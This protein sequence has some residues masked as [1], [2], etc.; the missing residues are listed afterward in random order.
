MQMLVAGGLEYGIQMMKTEMEVLKVTARPTDHY[1]Y[2]SSELENRLAT[3]YTA[4]SRTD[5]S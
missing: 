4:E 1:T 5:G 2:D 3:V